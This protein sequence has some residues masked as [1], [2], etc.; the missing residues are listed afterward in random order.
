MAIGAALGLIHHVRHLR[1]AGVAAE[2][3]RRRRALKGNE[4]R[5]SS[6]VADEQ[7]FMPSMVG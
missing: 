7:V 2:Q 3:F 4:A 5:L 1:E 6:G